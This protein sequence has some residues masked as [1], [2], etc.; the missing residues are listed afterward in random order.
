MALVCA[1]LQAPQQHE[2]GADDPNGA[3]GAGGFS[4]TIQAR[5]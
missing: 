2:N 3:D 4:L 5:V 1:T